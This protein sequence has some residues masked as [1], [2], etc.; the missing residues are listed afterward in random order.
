MTTC[1]PDILAARARHYQ[2]IADAAKGLPWHEIMEA[3]AREAHE[4]MVEAAER[5]CAAVNQREG[6]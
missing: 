4:D 6:K 3:K 5:E 2:E 1:D